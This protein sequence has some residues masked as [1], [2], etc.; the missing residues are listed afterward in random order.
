MK[1]K[2]SPKTA[3]LNMRLDE[4][5]MARIAE[6]AEADGRS[7]TNWVEQV[8]ARELARHPEPLP[9]PDDSDEGQVVA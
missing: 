9:F 5:M 7:T 1:P 2:R 6:L 4:I 8:L 3:R